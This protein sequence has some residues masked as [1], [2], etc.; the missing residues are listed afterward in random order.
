MSSAQTYELSQL[1]QTKK[2]ELHR[3]RIAQVY[4]GQIS[5]NET[6]RRAR[7]RIDW[8]LEQV[9]GNWVYD[10]GCSEGVTAIKLGQSG[11]HVDAIDINPEVVEYAQ[12]L[13]ND[14]APN[15][16]DNISFLVQDLFALKVIEPK[17][18]TVILG[19]VVEHV[20]EPGNM[21]KRAVLSTKVG[22]RII[23]TTPWGYFPAPDHHQT[24]FL[25]NF[26]GYIPEELTCTH[27][28]VVDGYIR[29]VAT[30]SHDP[31]D[32]GKSG[33]PLNSDVDT[34]EATLL[35]MTERAALEG[36]TFLRNVLSG[37][38]D[39]LERARAQAEKLSSQH[40]ADKNTF[41]KVQADLEREQQR[42]IQENSKLL[43]QQAALLMERGLFPKTLRRARHLRRLI[44]QEGPRETARRYSRALKRRIVSSSIGRKLLR[45]IPT[46]VKHK[47]SVVVTSRIALHDP[48]ALH[49]LE[50]AASRDFVIVCNS[51]PGADQAYGGEFIRTRYKAYL[52]SGLKGDIIHLSRSA[53]LSHI[54]DFQ[55]TDGK[56]LRIPDAH[57]DKIAQKLAKGTCMILAHS[58]SPALQ[59]A[60]QK[61][62]SSHERLAYWFHGF[63]VRDQ[64]R[65]YFNY[66]TQE[67]ATMQERLREIHQWRIETNKISLADA[68]IKKFFVSSYLKNIAECDM[69]TQTRNAHI[70]PN[71]INSNDFPYLEKTEESIRRF[72]LIRSFDR[73]NYANDIAIE[74]IK[75]ASQWEGFEK[76]HFTIRGFGAEFSP[77]T[78]GIKHLS[79]VD[80]QEQY[81]TPEQMAELH[82][83]HGVFL[84]PSRFD[85][86]GVTMCEAM[87]SGLVCI[88]NEV[89]GIPE[90][91]DES[92]GVLVPGNNP[93]AF[94]EAIWRV[95]QN[96]VEM[97]ARSKAAQERVRQQ[98]GAEQTVDKEIAI[99]LSS[100]AVPEIV[101]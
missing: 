9:E 10:I 22:G 85:T 16:L 75:I 26:L 84:C 18:D 57:T 30:K 12:A 24:Y 72:L 55:D 45:F 59:Q 19:E 89:A 98:C 8:T 27:L 82:K 76:L 91:M 40:T 25:T 78:S 7:D 31:R 38:N 94:A 3:D 43:A 83:D 101:D 49:A 64:R 50:Q 95:Q 86:Q 17:Y 14:I 48:S 70:V 11:R 54:E 23:I 1:G 61:S 5:D 41:A 62:I 99:A 73:R 65:L 42:L 56:I 39:L 69:G 28:S 46:R 87:S 90:F 53:T 13:A 29:F 4:F 44:R 35:E 21:I 88:T 74:A 93:K 2:Q 66:T 100:T 36:Q 63:E 81:S 60:L 80:I 34:S 20:F 96:P 37:R 47:A 79:N 15:A 32:N 33:S 97:L 77:L 71:F 6:Q 92:C 52:Q 58:P 67:M 51:F 68:E